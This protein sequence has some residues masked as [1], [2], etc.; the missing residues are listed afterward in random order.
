MKNKEGIL[1]SHELNQLKDFCNNCAKEDK[2]IWRKKK[3]PSYVPIDKKPDIP[4][5]KNMNNKMGNKSYNYNNQKMN[6]NS[7]KKFSESFQKNW[8]YL[9]QIIKNY[10]IW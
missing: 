4:S 3:N 1:S 7:N 2:K 9:N 10:Y 6:N 5:S 8:K